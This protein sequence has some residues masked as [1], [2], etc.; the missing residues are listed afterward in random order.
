MATAQQYDDLIKALVSAIATDIKA[1][2]D[3][4]AAQAGTHTDL[5]GQISFQAG[6]V[7]NINNTLLNLIN[8]ALTSGAANT[9]SVDKIKSEIDARVS[10]ALDGVDPALL[11]QLSELIAEIHADTAGLAVVVAAIGKALRVDQVQTFTDAEKEQAR[12]NLDLMSRTEVTT[13][14]S[15]AVSEIQVDATFPDTDYAAFYAA[16]KASA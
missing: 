4:L 1:A 13:A 6:R 16:A 12:A 9:W 11:Q 5:Y 7:D 14:I 8:D 3:A 2:Q 10:L 15:T